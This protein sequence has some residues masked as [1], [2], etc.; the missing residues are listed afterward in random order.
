MTKRGIFANREA[1]SHAVGLQSV[2]NAPFG[3][4]GFCPENV[5]NWSD[6]RLQSC[7]TQLDRT[8]DDGDFLQFIGPWPLEKRETAALDRSWRELRLVLRRGRPISKNFGAKAHANVPTDTFSANCKSSCI[9]VDLT[10]KSEK[11]KKILV[12]DS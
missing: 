4:F 2:E 5:A 9:E 12:H 6:R 7:L 11:V 1:N 8:N 10:L 3:T